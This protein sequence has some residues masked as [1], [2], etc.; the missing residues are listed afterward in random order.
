[1]LLRAKSSSSE[2]LSSLE[3]QKLKNRT[4]YSKILSEQ[5]TL[6]LVSSVTSISGQEAS[7]LAIC[8][9]VSRQL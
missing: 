1:M 3:F 9:A 7:C 2:G 6:K 4:S 5:R 8:G